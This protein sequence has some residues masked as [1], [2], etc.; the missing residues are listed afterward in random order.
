MGANMVRRLMRAGH[1]C[2]VFDLDSDAVESSP[3]RAPSAPTRSRTWWPSSTSPALG[4]VDGP[5]RR[6]STR[7]STTR[8]RARSGDIVI[9]GGNSYYRDDIRRAAELAE[10]RP[11][12]RRLGTS[13]GV[14]GLDRGYCLM[15]GGD[16]DAVKR[17][18]P[19]FATLAP[20]RRL[21]AAHPGARRRADARRAGLP[22]LR[23]ERRRPLREDG[24][25]RDRVRHDGGLRRGP[26]HPAQRQRRQGRSARSTPRPR[27][28][29]HPEYYQYDIDLPDGRRGVAPR[30]RDRLVAAGPDR[31]SAAASPPT[32]P[33]SP[34][35]CRTPA[36]AAGRRSP[37]STRAF[38]RRC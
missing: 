16:D 6:S 9:D 32:S 2:V 25:Q 23:A 22:P 5:G 4:L 30:Q 24:P 18:D 29:E 33:S 21:G 10:Q 27:R 37:R 20:G 38:P 35:G 26:E 8:P 31:R 3:V 12:L 19:I 15:I 36:R 7:R 34:A 11:P 28:C 17:L 14:W 13:G 1:E